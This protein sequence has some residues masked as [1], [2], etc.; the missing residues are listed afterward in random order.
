LSQGSGAD[1]VLKANGHRLWL[2]S[3]SAA[4]G[5]LPL[6]ADKHFAYLD[7]AASATPAGIQSEISRFLR[8]TSKSTNLL[9]IASSVAGNPATA[10]LKIVITRVSRD[11]EKPL[12]DNVIK[13]GDKIRVTLTN[14]SRK[15]LDVTAFY[16]N[17]KYAV[18]VMFPRRGEANR[19]EY[20]AT[21]TVD[22]D[23][24]DSTLGLER[25]AVVGVEAEKQ[26]E[27]T[28]LSFLAQDKLEGVAVT[29]GRGA[30]TDLFSDAGFADHVTRGATPSPAPSSTGMQVFTFSVRS[31]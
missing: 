10:A 1:V 3:A 25:L 21:E 5:A 19:L 9:R 14:T 6:A 11:G 13:A 7:A 27:R 8:H 4:Q 30:L 16:L 23:F 29:R 2:L 12:V 20:Q 18:D 24:D 15:P 22:I 28:D 26:G 31:N 17:S